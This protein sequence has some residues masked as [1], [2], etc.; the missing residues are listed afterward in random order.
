MKPKTEHVN[1][2]SS[3]N[4]SSTEKS[5]EKNE[6]RGKVKIYTNHQLF[7]SANQVEYPETNTFKDLIKKIYIGYQDI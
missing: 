2:A 1:K 6:L 3:S 7:F 4:A 5:T